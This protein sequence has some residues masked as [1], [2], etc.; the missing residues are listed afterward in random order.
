[1]QWFTEIQ[2]KGMAL[3]IGVKKKIFEGK[4]DFQK[5]SVFNTL[6]F[7]RM[8]TLDD[9][10]MLTERDEFV[11]HEMIVHPVS[12]ML[13]KIEK[14]LV[15]GGG[16]GGTVRELLRYKSI[17]RIVLVEIDKMVIDISKRY[18][19]TLGKYLDDKRVEVKIMDGAEFVKNTNEYFNLV[20][21]DS[22]DPVGP[23]EVLFSNEFIK[24]ISRITK[25][26]VSQTESPFL[27][28]DFIN[29]YHKD[30]KKY[31]KNIYF[32]IAHIPTYP[33]GLWSFTIGTNLKLKPRGN[34]K[35]NYY[36]PEVFKA[37]IVIPPV[38]KD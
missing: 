14:V 1:M 16:D 21:V 19:K 26:L 3:S 31:F 30:I 8:L 18:F 11:Y 17:K 38:Y 12:Q 4:S 29:R 20:I 22:T 32:Y 15:I 10:I 13:K 25:N 28:K 37:S 9:K 33:S 34:L 7:G 2:N 5:V 27:S 36:T 23:G 6:E 24:N 35:L